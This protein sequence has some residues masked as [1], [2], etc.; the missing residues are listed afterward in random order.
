MKNHLIKNTFDWK[1]DGKTCWGWIKFS[2]D[3]TYTTHKGPG[4]YEV[5]SSRVMKFKPGKSFY[6]IEFNEDGSLGLLI[7][8][9]RDISIPKINIP[10]TIAIFSVTS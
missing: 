7:D 8:P 5:I 4:P 6:T 1:K 10:N 2:D 9:V 3:D